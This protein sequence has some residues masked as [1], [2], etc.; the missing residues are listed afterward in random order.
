MTLSKCCFLHY[1]IQL[2][3]VSSFNFFSIRQQTQE[4]QLWGEHGETFDEKTI[5]EKSKQGIV[6]VVFSSFTSG[7][8]KGS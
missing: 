2:P 6:I 3:V 1:I 4:I 8:F 7:G 5:I